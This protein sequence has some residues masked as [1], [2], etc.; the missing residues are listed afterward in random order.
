MFSAA[1][2]QNELA[3]VEAEQLAER[4]Y[5]QA[6]SVTPHVGELTTRCYRPSLSQHINH[7]FYTNQFTHTTPPSTNESLLLYFPHSDEL[8]QH[9]LIEPYYITGQSFTQLIV[10]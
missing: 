10:I 6:L 3:G 7:C 1:R 8:T 5:H 9:L 2:Y 4:F